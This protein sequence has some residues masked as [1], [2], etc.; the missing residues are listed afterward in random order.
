MI[1][2]LRTISIHGG[3]FFFLVLILSGTRRKGGT[4]EIRFSCWQKTKS[5]FFT[6]EQ[7]RHSLG[8]VQKKIR[9]MVPKQGMSIKNTH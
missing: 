3:F 9:E 1:D 2:V 4:R 6:G 8:E 5:F 7:T